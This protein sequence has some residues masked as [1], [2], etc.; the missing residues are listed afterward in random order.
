MEGNEF[1]LGNRALY[2]MGAYLAVMLMI[3]WIGRRSRKEE[4]LR[5]FYLAG[6]TFGFVVLFLTLFATQYSGNTLLGFAGRAYR[7]GATY[8]VSVMFMTMVITV[9]T[10]YAPR[11]VRLARTFGYITPPDYVYHR[12]GSPALHI[13][14]VIL[15]VWGLANYVLE[16]LVAMGHAMVTIS[17][18]NISFMWGV[19]IL[20]V[21]MLTYE[22]LGGMRSVAWTDVIQGTILLAGLGCILFMLLTIDGGLSTAHEV[23]ASEAPE[24]L[25][26]PDTAGLRTWFSSL[27]LLGFG[28]SV[29]PHAMQRLFAAKSLRTLRISLAGMAFMPLTTT[30]LAFLMG[31]LALSRFPEL[32]T[33]ESDRV[34]ILVLIDMTKD[35]PITYWLVVLIF[36][37]IVAAIMS[38]ADSALLSISSMFTKDIYKVYINKEATP[39][40]LLMVGKIFGWGLIAV[41]VAMAWISEKTESSIWMLIRLK[42]EFLVQISPMF[43]LG[44]HWRKLP[45][46]AVLSG[47]I[48]GTGI[49]LIIWS[50]VMIGL[51]DNRSPWNVSAGV[52][53]L[54]AN[55]AIC[56]AGGL[57]LPATSAKSQGLRT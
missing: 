9:F 13:G 18:G 15:L 46:S 53:G 57:F 40:H 34:T 32:S 54:A 39:H 56:I 14:A 5:D 22:T 24:K 27:I 31:Y 7:Q 55:Y 23:I 33:F 8:I 29:Y 38:T 3:G 21:V 17:D 4:S 47:L 36:A 37:A 19:I 52:W 42:L 44:I 26:A 50:G 41:L 11:L 16:N 45:A 20:V 30:L 35:S 12:F 48:V 2:V 28:V 43:V 49:T 6:S 51:W 25:A 10:I 1:Q